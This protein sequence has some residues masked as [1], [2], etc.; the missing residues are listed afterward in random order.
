L[1]TK[2]EKKLYE[3]MFLVDSA[4]AASDWDGI[5]KAI[6]KI[7][8]KAK[9][10]I[11]SIRK[12]DDRKLAYDIKG[13]S[14]GTYLLCY[15]RADGRQIQGIEKAVQLSEKI[16]RV[17]VLNTDQMTQ[18]DIEKDTPAAKAEK[19]QE[20]ALAEQTKEIE[21]DQQDY[22]GQALSA[23]DA[24]ITEEA[25]I[26]EEAQAAEQTKVVEDIE[27][28]EETEKLQ[29]TEKTEEAGQAEE[30]EDS[31]PKVVSDD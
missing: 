16:I 6:R 12:W 27:Q 2:A 18:A 25:P 22:Q 21:E 24:P 8:D 4:K 3:G 19:E 28:V 1:D 17:L 23:E 26:V 20:K 15:F 31:Q 11:V 5:N 7:L 29:E 30:P 9:A 10:E 14:R 13:T